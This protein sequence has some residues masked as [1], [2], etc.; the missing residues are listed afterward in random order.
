VTEQMEELAEIQSGTGK[1]LL[2]ARRENDG[3][4]FLYSPASTH[5]AT[6]TRGMPT[7][8][9][10]AV[11]GVEGSPS[12]FASRWLEYVTANEAMSRI[13]TDMGFQYD[14][15]TAEQITG[16][17]LSRDGFRVLVLPYAQAFSTEV[18]ETIRQFVAD[19]GVVVAD[20]RPGIFDGH[21]RLLETGQLDEVFGIERI[22]GRALPEA[23]KMKPLSP[24]AQASRLPD[25][26]VDHQVKVGSGAAGAHVDGVSALIGHRAGKGRAILFNF[27]PGRY[28]ALRTLGREQAL[29]RSIGRMLTATGIEPKV[30]LASGGENVPVTQIVRFT[31]GTNEYVG[32]LR[33]HNMFFSSPVRVADQAP[34]KATLDFGREGY[35]Y[36]VRAGKYKGRKQRITTTVVPAEAQLYAVL[37]YRLKTIRVA[38]ASNGPGPEKQFAL[39]IVPQGANTPGTH[40]LHVEVEDASGRGRPEYAQNLAVEHGAGTFRLP[41]A[42]S[43]PTGKWRLRVRDAATGVVRESQFSHRP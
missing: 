19:G 34:R 15:V 20:L 38:E 4:A 24:P 6:L 8:E 11:P 25:M 37:P 30:T 22:G 39:Q 2:S 1:L 36:D 3:I 27:F 17:R 35:V 33:D 13:F 12:V 31:H 42:L 14:Y 16:G 29:L 40:V 32:L 7:A 43:D 9:F 23:L 5:A 28:I 18:A 26:P 10:A 21:G 41:L